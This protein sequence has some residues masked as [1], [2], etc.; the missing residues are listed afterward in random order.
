MSK[1]ISDYS[2]FRSNMDE[3]IIG[4][5]RRLLS[6]A[7]VVIES[8]KSEWGFGQC[9]MN[10][11][12]GPALDLADQHVL[13]KHGIREIAA[14]NG[15]QATFMAKW[16]EKHS[17]NGCH[18]HCSLWKDGENAFADPSQDHGMSKTA[19]HFMGGMMAL[20]KD[21]QL[22]YAPTINSYKR[23]EDL[24][25]APS[26]VT[27]GGDNRTVAFRIAGH[28]A[29]TR[30]ENRIPGTDANAHLIYA[31]MIASGLYGV[32]NEIE[33]TT[34]FV[35]A[36]AYELKRATKL[37]RTL[38]DAATV[39]HKSKPVRAILGDDV[40]DHYVQVARWEVEEYNKAVTDW[41]RRR[42]FELI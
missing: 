26:T 6:E 33:P 21:F 31:A 2:I 41:E 28:G 16:D 22:F 13:T 8:Y 12:Y 17:G 42:Y 20:A 9:E 29:S 1:Y 7:G 30:I 39:M 32:E 36:N 3:W 11:R 14:L 24:S 19:R 5:M 37:S 23:Q 10:L 15:V 25:F 34:P 27:W 40:V 38:N 35:E 4:P 18:V